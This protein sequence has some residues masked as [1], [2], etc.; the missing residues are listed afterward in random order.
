[1]SV[2]DNGGRI[3]ALSV[4]ALNE[5]IKTLLDT[6]DVLAAVAVRGEI[7]NFKNHY[8]TGHF[9]FTLKDDGGCIAAVMFRSYASH[10]DFVPENGMKAVL[11]GH[12]SSYVKSGQY[13]IY[14]TD[15]IPDGAG[16]LYLRFEQLKAR[17]ETEGLFDASHKKPIPKYPERIGVVTSPTGAAIQDI[18]NILG[19]RFPYAEVTL[20][21]ALVQGEGA[22]AS[23]MSGIEYF[24]RMTEGAPDV[25]II[26]RGGGSIEDLWAFN[27]EKLART[28]A[29]SHIPIIS[30]VGH[31]TDFTIAD[32]VADL[33]APTPSAAAELAVPDSARLAVQLS[34]VGARLSSLLGAKLEHEKTRL[35]ALASR[36]SLTDPSFMLDMRRTALLMSEERLG[37]VWSSRLRA[38]RSRFA[39]ALASL[40]AMNPLAV[41]SRGYAAVHS[42]DGKK[43]I[44]DVGGLTPGDRIRLSMRDGDVSATVDEVTEKKNG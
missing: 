41:L 9:Y 30:A 37:N 12:V 10:L 32:F 34:N 31:E 42:E 35:A 16:A 8:Q 40:D 27:G 7:S 6:D 4:T 25:L 11:F 44:T 19:R 15:M 36:R 3:E 1:M 22:E 26:G 17:L 2:L 28:I 20:Y 21:P 33:R 29:A 39:T 24:N 14:V 43:V 13:Q 18:L 23:V 5:Y 38:A